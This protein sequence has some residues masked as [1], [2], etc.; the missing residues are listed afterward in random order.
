MSGV[1]LAGGCVLLSFPVKRVRPD[2]PSSLAQEADQAAALAMPG[3]RRLSAESIALEQLTAALRAKC[4]A[5]GNPEL[6][7]QDVRNLAIAIAEKMIV[8]RRGSVT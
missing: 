3:V 8:D 6:S 7:R 2:Q 4:V 5:E 1:P